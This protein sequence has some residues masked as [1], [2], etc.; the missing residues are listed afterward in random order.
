MSTRCSMARGPARS[1]SLVTWPTRTTGTP[2]D[3]ASR[4]N[5]STHALDL[6]QASRR[7]RQFVVGNGL[8]GVDDDQRRPMAHDGGLDGHHVG[9]GQGQQVLGHRTDAAGPPADL[10]QGLLG[11]GQQHF[12]AGGGHRRQD[13][14]E[15]GGLAD[16]RWPE[17]Q[18]HRTRDE[19]APED[20]V[21]LRPRR[22]A[23]AGP[24]PRP[25]GATRPPAPNPARRTGT[26]PGAARWWSRCSIA[27]NAGS[28][29]PIAGRLRH[30]RY[31]DRSR[32]GGP[33]RAPYEGAVTTRRTAGPRPAVL[34]A[35]PC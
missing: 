1:P 11:R 18:G 29:P 5:R 35:I 19:A 6:G 10:G 24:R 2:V 4:V 17:D 15:E 21:D 31:R 14:E 26:R 28:G 30:R 20:P 7:P 27:R 22:W 13:L 34:R 3:L 16:A 23:S 8:D 32:L 33:C 9:P 12:G 25:P